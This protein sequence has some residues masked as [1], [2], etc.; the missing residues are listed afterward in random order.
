M[1]K[2]YVILYG[3]CKMRSI[4]REMSHNAFSSIFNLSR[5]LKIKWNQYDD[6]NY[7]FHY[8]GGR[9]SKVA[10]KKKKWLVEANFLGMAM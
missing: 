5:K 8:S 7:L 2:Y 1:Y 9:I 10:S 6:Y 4:I 3:N